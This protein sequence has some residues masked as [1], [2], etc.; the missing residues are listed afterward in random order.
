MFS[1]LDTAAGVFRQLGDTARLRLLA[2][3]ARGE[4]SVGD[5]V[6]ATGLS[7]P[8]VS[9]HLK[10]L[11]Q[12]ALV[13]RLR[14]GQRV[15]YRLPDGATG[16]FVRSQLTDLWPSAPQ[17]AADV[18]RL[19]AANG[20]P[21]PGSADERVLNRAVL[22]CLIGRPVGRLLDIGSGA[23]RMLS[24]L[25]DAAT[26]AVGVDVD[27]AA[28]RTARYRLS[29]AGLANCSIQAA[30]IES[31]PFADDAFDTVIVDDVL[32]DVGELDIALAETARVLAPDGLVLIV[33]RGADSALPRTRTIASHAGNAGLILAPARAVTSAATS[34]WLA[35]ARAAS[36]TRLAS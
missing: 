30:G 27:A 34:W 15:Y 4:Q 21:E 19:M 17:L 28:R 25:S 35:V 22:D 3:C 31:L 5:L 12:H 18:E 26:T 6:T 7:Q 32:R 33:E 1:D 16:S 13:E 36:D 14:D 9:Q 10:A 23:A 20:E 11:A 29:S 2:L 24:L 8:R